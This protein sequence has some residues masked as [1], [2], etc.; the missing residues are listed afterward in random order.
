MWVQGWTRT[1]EKRLAR[2]WVLKELRFLDKGPAN[3][4]ITHSHSFEVPANSGYTQGPQMIPE[5]L[6]PLGEI[7]KYPGSALRVSLLTQ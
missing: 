2:D 5:S 6:V 1:R 7:S 3:G 4:Y